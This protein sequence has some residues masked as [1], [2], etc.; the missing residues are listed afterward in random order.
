MNVA[1]VTPSLRSSV[2]YL[3]PFS[4]VETLLAGGMIDS[5]TRLRGLPDAPE[6]GHGVIGGRVAAA[7]ADLLA[8]YPIDHVYA[9]GDVVLLDA[10]RRDFDGPLTVLLPA[11]ATP[12]LVTHF[13]KVVDGAVEVGV[14]PRIPSPQGRLPGLV[15]LGRHSL[16]A[17]YVSAESRAAFEQFS[18]PLLGFSILID[19][20]DLGSSI[21]NGWSYV[22]THRFNGSYRPAE[23]EAGAHD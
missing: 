16:S 12:D 7:V 6:G 23:A 10:I 3:G 20:S 2:D 11:D 19:P 22:W 13:E 14:L 18:S 4:V 15:L 17:S 5:G 21:P 8:R 1:G 9:V